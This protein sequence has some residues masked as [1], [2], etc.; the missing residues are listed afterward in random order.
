MESYHC[1]PD[2]FAVIPSFPYVYVQSGDPLSDAVIVWTRYTPTDAN[3]TVTLELR[4]A[5]VDAELAVND[6]LDPAKNTNLQQATVQ[7]S[8]DSDFIAKIDVVGLQANTPYVFAFVDEDG[9]PSPVGQT[10]TAPGPE[11]SIESMVY[12]VF[13]CSHFS[14]GYF[15]AYDIASTIENLDFWVHVGDYVYEYGLYSTYA[16]DS[17]ERVNQTLPKWEQISL[18]DHRNRMATYHTDEGLLNL[19]RRAPLIAS[20]DDHETTNNP[21]GQGTRNTT[22]A[23]NHQE[24]CPANATSPDDEKRAGNCDRPEGDIVER[25]NAAAQSYFEWMPIRHFPGSMG[26]VDVGTITQVISWGDMAT[27]VTFDT[28]LSHRSKD[29]TLNSN[30]WGYF[31]PF[32]TANTDVSQYSNTSSP[33]YQEMVAVAE[34]VTAILESDEYSLIGEDQDIIRN[35]FKTSTEAGQTWQ[36]YAGATALGRAV[37]GDYSMMYEFIEDPLVAG[38]V[39]NIT[40]AIFAAGASTFLRVLKAHALT[41]IPWNRDDYS[42]FAHEQRQILAMFKEVSTNPIVLGGDLHDGYGWTLFEDGAVNGTPCAVNLVCPGVTS[43][44]SYSRKRVN[45]D[46][47]QKA[48]LII[49]PLFHW[50]CT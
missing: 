24:T 5:A 40:A 41:S 32:A 10:K 4:M 21:W 36:I 39:E 50:I 13:S 29:P 8:G 14:N 2:R 30:T 19:R 25:F 22:G 45:M 35:S 47:T 43:P 38:A 28:R 15:H 33:V 6:H 9:K 7:V 16:T 18:Q 34:Q 49:I 12:A 11:D 48:Q 42:G 31:F 46:V 20:W 3:A 17:P 44:V 1:H 37:K 23:Q 26:V 27:I